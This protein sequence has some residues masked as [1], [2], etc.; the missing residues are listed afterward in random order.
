MSTHNI[1]FV[2]K[3]EKYFAVEKKFYLE[4]WT[5]QKCKLIRCS[6]IQIRHVLLKSFDIH[7]NICCGYSLELPQEGNS[8]EQS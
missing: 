1:R 5:E 2:Q 8:G 3:L 6:E 4:L 7:E